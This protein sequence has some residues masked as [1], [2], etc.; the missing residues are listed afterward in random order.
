MHHLQST[1]FANIGAGLGGGFKNAKELRVMN[2]KEAVNGPDNKR[3]KAEV[4][5]EY[6]QMLANKVFEIVL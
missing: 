5:N 4:K 1:E 3:W 2:Y 6:W